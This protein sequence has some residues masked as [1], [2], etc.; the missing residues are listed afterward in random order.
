MAWMKEADQ[1]STEIFHSRA[2][3]PGMGG[4]STIDGVV[5]LQFSLSSIVERVQSGPKQSRARRFLARRSV[6]LTA[7]AALKQS[8]Q[9][10]K[11]PLPQPLRLRDFLVSSAER[12]FPRP[13][14]PQ[15]L[16]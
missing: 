14:C 4:G 10:G 3:S 5:S 7:R 1:P 16:L 9:E 12:R 6:P 13:F 8:R 11:G 15:I 2:H